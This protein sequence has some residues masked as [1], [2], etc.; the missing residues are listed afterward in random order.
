MKSY[1][2]QSGNSGVEAYE[3]GADYIMVIFSTG[4]V[5]NYLYTYNS[6][7]KE[8]VEMMK[9]LAENGFGLNSF[10]SRYI[11]NQYERKW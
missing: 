3:I 6:A 4:K 8:N 2:N 1:L 11:R 7:G 9:Q 5:R 10:I